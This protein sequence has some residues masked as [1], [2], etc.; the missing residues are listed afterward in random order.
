V[1]KPFAKGFSTSS[2]L[3]KDP[4]K[5]KS[6]LFLQFFNFPLAFLLCLWHNI[7]EF[8]FDWSRKLWQK[9]K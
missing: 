4:E 8:F 3:A 6:L 1:E 7:G 9:F 2:F 5:R